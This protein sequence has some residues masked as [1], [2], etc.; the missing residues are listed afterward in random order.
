[1]ISSPSG[2]GVPC[3]APLWPA[4]YLPR[5]GVDWQLRRRGPISPLA[6]EIAGRPEGGAAPLTVLAKYFH[7]A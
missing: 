7:A 5:K 1:M 3:I 6:G 4:R 2:W